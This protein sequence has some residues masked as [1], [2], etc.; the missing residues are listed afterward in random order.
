MEQGMWEGKY[1]GDKK[2]AGAISDSGSGT[3]AWREQTRTEQ[4]VRLS[5]LWVLFWKIWEAVVNSFIPSAAIAI[6][7][8]P[9]IATV[10]S[11]GRSLPV[12]TQLTV[13]LYLSIMKHFTDAKIVQR[14]DTLKAG[15]SAAF[16][17][18]LPHEQDSLTISYVG[19]QRCIAPSETHPVS[20]CDMPP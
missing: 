8:Q 3:L 6:R 1:W 13:L 5:Q 19:S 17:S 12:W 10:E 16:S 2:A 20:E 18:K 4:K 14:A 9:R 15:F 7:A 11:L